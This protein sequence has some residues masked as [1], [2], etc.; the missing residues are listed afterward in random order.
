L[1][2][3]GRRNL[4]RA[5]LPNSLHAYPLNTRIGHSSSSNRRI[6]AVYLNLL[7]P[8]HEHPTGMSG[9]AAS[10]I[11]RGYA[12]L[13]HHLH[14]PP[15]TTHSQ[16]ETLRSSIAYHLAYGQK[17]QPN[18]QNPTPL[19]AAIVG[20]PVFR[21]LDQV[22]VETINGD[23]RL[24][25]LLKAFRHAVHYKVHAL[26]GKPDP[27]NP[28]ASTPSSSSQGILSSVFSLPIESKLS[29]WTRDIL[30]GLQGGPSAARFSCLGGLLAG[31]EDLERQK[32]A[33][34]A[35]HTTDPD[36]K[37]E[38]DEVVAVRRRTRGKVEEEVIVALAEV[39]EAYLLPL[40]DQLANGGRSG[41]EW[42]L[43][44]V[45]ST[46]RATGRS[47]FISR[48]CPNT[49]HLTSTSPRGS[50][51]AHICIILPSSTLCR[52]GQIEGIAS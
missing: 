19:A 4:D 51:N 13:L 45:Q 9:I 52:G 31:L 39:M 12:S 37:R 3:A 46:P 47:E 21:F 8:L 35:G 41:L 24:E 30:N 15:T 1:A 36:G 28:S 17:G 2:I 6:C 10:Q 14:R 16:L 34:K 11:D 26:L 25:M 27:S 38:V 49:L 50:R 33:R 22:D 40:S 42:E 29:T 23:R 32:A 43:E 18:G 7:P 5:Q 44:F 20:S 48:T